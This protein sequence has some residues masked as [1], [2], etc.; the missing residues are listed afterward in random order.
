[1]TEDATKATFAE[2]A[3]KIHAHYEF[4]EKNVINKGHIKL[5]EIK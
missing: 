2:A 3:N 4:K 5:K 1:M